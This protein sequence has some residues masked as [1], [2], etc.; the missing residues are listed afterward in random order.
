MST[1]ART[2]CTQLHLLGKAQALELSNTLYKFAPSLLS[3]HMVVRDKRKE[4]LRMRCNSAN[5]QVLH[6]YHRLPVGFVDWRQILLQETCVG[7]AN[8]AK[9]VLALC[10][11]LSL[12]IFCFLTRVS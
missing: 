5:G 2:H 12:A 8:I 1:R 10:V 4:L 3:V 6:I 9:Q 11:S 7:S